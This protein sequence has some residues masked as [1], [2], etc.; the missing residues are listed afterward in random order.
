MFLFDLATYFAQQLLYVYLLGVCLGLLTIPPFFGILWVGRFLLRVLQTAGFAWASLFLFVVRSLQR[1]VLRTGLSFLAIFVLV[2]VV[3]MIWSLLQFLDDFTKQKETSDLKVIASVKHEFFGSMPPSYAERLYRMAM[4]LPPSLRPQ[5]GRDD[6]MG[7]SF[8][9]GTLDPT[10][11]AYEN[12]LGFIGVRPAVVPKMFDGLDEFTPEQLSR[13]EQVVEVMEA[14]PQGVIIGASILRRINKRVGERIQ[15]TCTNFTGI[16]FDFDIVGA[17]PPGRYDQAAAM[18]VAYLH[19]SLD[20]YERQSGGVHPQSEKTLNFIWIRLPSQA[21]FE[22]LASVV[23]SPGAFATPALKLETA[24]SSLANWFEPYRDLLWGMRWLLAPGILATM[25]LIIAN[26]I[27][28]T[29]RERRTEMAVLKVLGFR[30]WQVMAFVLGE[31]MLIGGLSGGLS[32]VLMYTLVQA[33][34]GIPLGFL[35]IMFIP[36]DALWWGLAIGISTAV[37]GSLV[38]AWSAAT[39]KVSEVFARVA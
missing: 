10:K 1:N 29:V 25:T 20:D 36:I 16:V 38:P 8:V 19:S 13:L 34:G 7:W 6:F 37:L 23:E 17:F 2:V 12:N 28:I 21:S 31:A 30:P 5:Q 26:A 9:L 32:S 27:S 33:F 3:T 18:N 24:S 11:D 39:V 14:K 4:D 35:P 22:A 15:V